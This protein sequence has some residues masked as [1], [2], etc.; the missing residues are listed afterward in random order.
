ME[1]RAS[2]C[3]ATAPVPDVAA[4]VHNAIA[5]HLAAAPVLYAAAPVQNAAAPVHDAIAVHHAAAPVQDDAAPVQDAAALVHDA[6][7]AVEEFPAD[8]VIA[9]KVNA[10][11]LTKST[12]AA[13][14][15]FDGIKM[16]AIPITELLLQFTNI[17]SISAENCGL[18]SLDT[19]PCKDLLETLHL[20][21]N[22]LAGNALLALRPCIKLTEIHLKGNGFTSAEQF[23]PLRKLPL[24][25][26]DVSFNPVTHCSSLQ[27]AMELLFPR[28]HTVV[29]TS[30]LDLMADESALEESDDED[31]EEMDTDTEESDFEEESEK[32]SVEMAAAV[33]ALEEAVCR[34]RLGAGIGSGIRQRGGGVFRFGYGR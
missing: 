20:D 25:W 4:P 12:D 9:A 30:I 21:D 11:L 6:D 2:V 10:Y 22:E 19:L 28:A 15:E 31:E 34:S 16:P 8:A 32:D 26:V 1:A 5:V 27:E 33:R 23:A 24:E 3:D 13:I 17:R 7:D 14:L 29:V 18:R